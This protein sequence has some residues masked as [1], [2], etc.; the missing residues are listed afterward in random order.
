M[1]VERCLFE[2]KDWKNAEERLVFALVL[3]TP[4]MQVFSVDKLLMLVR[5]LCDSAKGRPSLKFLSFWLPAVEKNVSG[6]LMFK[7]VV[8][9][10]KTHR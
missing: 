5:R 4:N 6:M 3:L 10:T 2:I 1:G 7:S 8:V 9:S